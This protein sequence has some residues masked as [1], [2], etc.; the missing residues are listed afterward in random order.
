MIDQTSPVVYLHQQ[1]TPEDAAFAE[2]CGTHTGG[3]VQF[4]MLGQ[5]AKRTHANSVWA[6][7][8][9]AIERKLRRWLIAGAG[10]A[11]GNLVTGGLYLLHRAEDT[12]AEQERAAELSRSVERYRQNTDDVIRE[13]R[14]D[15]R[16]L[17]AAMRRLSG[18][19]PDAP[20]GI[21]DRDT[22]TPN[23]M[24][25]EKMTMSLKRD[26]GAMCSITP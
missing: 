19:D 12:G 8:R 23:R 15:I 1:P 16:E 14:L 26:D 9:R 7:S 11:L 24:T 17:R 20:S 22:Y 25:S 18:L 3:E 13:L 5:V 4:W 21:I 2:A 10:L 6:A